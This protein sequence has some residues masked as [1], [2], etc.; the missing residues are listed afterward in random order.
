[1]AMLDMPARRRRFADAAAYATLDV[2]SAP[3]L[4]RRLSPTASATPLDD[5]A[6]IEYRCCA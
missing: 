6:D 5:A 3:A 2:S 4:R 1:M